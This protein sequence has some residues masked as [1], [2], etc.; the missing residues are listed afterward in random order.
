MLCQVTPASRAAYPDNRSFN[1]DL[2]QIEQCHNRNKVAPD[3]K[4]REIKG[5]KVPGL[6]RMTGS[7]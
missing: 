6:G 1:S 7:M 4:K 5:M 3:L 2:I